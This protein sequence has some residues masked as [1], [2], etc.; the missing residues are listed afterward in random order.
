MFYITAMR[1]IYKPQEARTFM[2][3]WDQIVKFITTPRPTSTKS[4]LPVWSPVIFKSQ[5]CT[6]NNVTDIAFAVMDVDNGTPFEEHHK[7][8]D[9]Q[10]IAHTTPSHRPDFHK[11]RLI[12]PLAMFPFG[13]QENEGHLPTD[14]FNWLGTWK[15]INQLFQDRT[16]SNLDEQCKD[17]RRF[18]Y[19]AQKS[20]HLMVH[21]NDG[22]Q[23][24]T[25]DYD[26][27][28]DDWN[29]EQIK[30]LERLEKMERKIQVMQNQPAYMRND[31]EELHLKLIVDSS[32]RMEFAHKI[33][34][35]IVGSGNGQRAEGWTCPS[36]HR[37][38]ATYFYIDTRFHRSTAQ[39]AHKNSC[40]SWWSLFNL[41]RILGVC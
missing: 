4:E 12:I 18:Y 36:C 15:Q 19:V 24:F 11:W 23:D 17:R 34:A 27:I 8:D 10:Y 5:P 38:D 39:C 22:G 25:P 35:Q 6:N 41:G 21:V 31:A 30:R 1:K 37:N 9:F 13:R 2:F 20:E 26:Q 40:D 3:S 33:A 29:E 14:D 28:V 32:Y 16:G 7:F